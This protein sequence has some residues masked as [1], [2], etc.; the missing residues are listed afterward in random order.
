MKYCK[1]V[2]AFTL[3]LVSLLGSSVFSYGQN[4]KNG[5]NFQAVARDNF[6]N[7]LRNTSINVLS[8][9]IQGAVNG[10][11]VLVEQTQVTT[12]SEGVFSISIGQGNPMGTPVALESID[13]A[14]GP[15][16]LNMKIS[17]SPIPPTSTTT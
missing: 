5:I 13:W 4:G 17:T 1:V 15:Y 8:S 9:V 14:N 2:I 3:I 7:P 11:V 12:N 16:F 6:K 10:T